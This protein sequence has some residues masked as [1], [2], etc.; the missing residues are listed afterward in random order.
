MYFHKGICAFISNLVRGFYIF[1]YMLLLFFFL[2]GERARCASH[3]API[4]FFGCCQ[5]L[6]RMEG[7]VDV[8]YGFDGVAGGDVVLVEEAVGAVASCPDA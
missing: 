4:L 5:L 2:C 3:I 6:L 7:E 8:F 1:I